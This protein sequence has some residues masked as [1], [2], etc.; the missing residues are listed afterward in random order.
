[1]EKQVPRCSD[2]L[3]SNYV[4]QTRPMNGTMHWKKSSPSSITDGKTDPRSTNNALNASNPAPCAMRHLKTATYTPIS[5][6]NTSILDKLFDSANGQAQTSLNYPK[7][8]R[9][10]R[11]EIATSHHVPHRNCVNEIYLCIR[12]L[13]GRNYMEPWSSRVCL[14]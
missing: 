3:E 9:M 2:T 5:P 12:R 1:M 8:M 14:K 6:P 7:L 10:R 4:C 11:W 13:L